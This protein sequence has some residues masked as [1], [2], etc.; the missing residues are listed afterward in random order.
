MCIYYISIV[1][2]HDL[3]PKSLSYTTLFLSQSLA[4]WTGGPVTPT[5]KATIRSVCI[6]RH[7][8]EQCSPEAIA[9]TPETSPDRAAIR[10]RVRDST[11]NH[12]SHLMQAPSV[13][14]CALAI[15]TCQQPKPQSVARFVKKQGH[16]QRR[17]PLKEW[18]RVQTPCGASSKRS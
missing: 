6:S 16:V 12:L 15:S 13:D 9:P 3:P 10:Q 18:W 1:G 4:E 7:S 11:R 17:R 2:W 14:H 8:V 5:D